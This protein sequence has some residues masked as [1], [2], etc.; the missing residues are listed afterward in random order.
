MINKTQQKNLLDVL[1]LFQQLGLNRHVVLIGSW[2]EY[3]YVDLFDG[4]YHPDIATRDI[5]FLYRNLRLPTHKIP[6]IKALKEHGFIYDENPLTKVARFY[7]ENI[8]ELEFMTRVVGPDQINYHIE[9][10]DITV[11]G[12]R[13]LNLLGKHCVEVNR[14]GLVIIVPQPA[15]YAIHKILIN[16]KR[17][18]QNKA[19]KDM[20]SVKN[21]LSQIKNNPTQKALFNTI[22]RGLSKKEKVIF[23]RVC[24]SNHIDLNEIVIVLPIESQ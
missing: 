19:A 6:L 10:L 24:R 5:D 18:K 8:L 11:E 3:F 17:V 2:V 14:D 20:R 7:K 1:T 23:E 13:E 22:I 4:D 21:I 12:I 15:S 9:S 16:E